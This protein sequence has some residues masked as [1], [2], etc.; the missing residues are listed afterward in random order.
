MAASA[1]EVQLE[2]MPRLRISN[3]KLEN[4]PSENRGL[5]IRQVLAG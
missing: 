1:N 4:A 5:R 2:V 3:L